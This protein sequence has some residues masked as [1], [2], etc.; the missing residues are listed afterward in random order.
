[1]KKYW[2]F[3]LIIQIVNCNGRLYFPAKINSDKETIAVLPFCGTGLSQAIKQSTADELSNYLYITKKVAV[4]DRS[5][6]NYMLGEL[7]IS[8]PYVLSKNQL[9]EISDSLGASIVAMGFISQHVSQDNL[10]KPIKTM[11]ITIRFIRA[12]SGMIIGIIQ[13]TRTVSSDSFQ[14]IRETIREMAGKIP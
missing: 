14:S 2:V 6:V 8:N 9:K 13:E 5:Q 3:F 1:M 7:G 4:I 12:E 10:E 11:T